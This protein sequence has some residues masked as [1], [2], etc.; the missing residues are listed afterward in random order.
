MDAVVEKGLAYKAAIIM[1]DERDLDQRHLLNL[2]HTFGHAF[3][4]SSRFALAHGEAVAIGLVYT[5]LLAEMRGAFKTEDVIR[6]ARLLWQFNLPTRLPSLPA[7]RI[8]AAM[9]AD[10]KVEGEAVYMA[11][12]HGIGA[13]VVEPVP[14]RALAQLLPQIHALARSMG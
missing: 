9:A 4:S 8:L 6:V 3:E 12:P 7:E 2:G 10:K 13:V 11:V 1:E 5:A 14:L